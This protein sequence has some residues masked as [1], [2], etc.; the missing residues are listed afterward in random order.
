M[1]TNKP[2]IRHFPALIKSRQLHGRIDFNGLQISIETGRSRCRE[3]HNPHD[4]SSGMSRMHL[5]YGYI[6]KTK[7]V[8]GDHY[9]C[10]V[11]PDHSAQNVYIITTMMAPDFTDVDEEKVMLGLNTPEEAK[12]AYLASYSDPRFFGS[13]T[14]MPFEEFKLKVLATKDEPK[15]IGGILQKSGEAMCK[16]LGDSMG[17]DW[18]KYNLD[19]FC[20][21][22]FDEQEHA[23]VV[24]HDDT[25]IARIV[26]E[27]LDEDP[28][29]YS[30]M[31]EIKKMG[32][33][34]ARAGIH[35]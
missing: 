12:R 33:L 21:G 15:L 35:Y 19:E 16:Q 22:M 26:M 24:G 14:E 1:Y 31:A 18:K 13:M 30:K 2:H 20:D 9:D 28:Y 25:K 8:D 29:Y 6:R 17:I 3:W 32:L 34:K 11:G 4:G 23:D 7:G 27:H 5:P 10:F